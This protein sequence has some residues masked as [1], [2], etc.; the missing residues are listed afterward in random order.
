MSKRLAL[1]LL[2][3]VVGSV[4][5]VRGQDVRTG[6]TTLQ[7]AATAMGAANLKSIHYSGTGWDAAVG[8]S[9]SANDDWPK[10]ELS[11]YSRTIDYE[12]KFS[13]EELTRKGEQQRV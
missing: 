5:S 6:R 7:A 10:F 8:Q 11:S 2:A 4:V 3:V 9:Y 13:K 1:V 12:A